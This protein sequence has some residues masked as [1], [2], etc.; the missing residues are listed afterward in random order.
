MANPIGF[1][2]LESI[3][4]FGEK[5]GKFFKFLSGNGWMNNVGIMEFENCVENG[6]EVLKGTLLILEEINIDFGK[7]GWALVLWDEEDLMGLPFSFSSKPDIELSIQFFKLGFRFQAKEDSKIFPVIW[8]A[9]EKKWVAEKVDVTENGVTRQVYAPMVFD[10]G[11]VD[12]KTGIEVGQLPDPTPD[13]PNNTSFGI[14]FD[15]EFIGNTMVNVTKAVALG[16]TGFVLEFKNLTFHFS[17]QN[18]PQGREAG[19]KGI[20]LEQCTFHFP[21]FM[22]KDDENSTA[23]IACTDLIIGTGGFS[24]HFKLTAHA[25]ANNPNEPALIKFKAGKS[26]IIV[27]DFEL[28]FDEGS[29]THGHMSGEVRFSNLKDGTEESAILAFECDITDYGFIINAEEPDGVVVD[30]GRFFEMQLFKLT[31]GIDSGE[32]VWGLKAALR[33][34]LKKGKLGKCLPSEIIYER[35]YSGQTRILP[36][37]EY[38]IVENKVKENKVKNG[39]V[40]TMESG[41]QY[42]QEFLLKLGKFAELYAFR[43][44]IGQVD[45]DPDFDAKITFD[46]KFMFGP[47][48]VS[49]KGLGVDLNFNNDPLLPR[50]NLGNTHLTASPILPSGFGIKIKTETVEGGGQLNIIDNG[51]RYEGFIS[52]NIKKKIIINGLTI[53]EFEDATGAPQFNFFVLLGVQFKPGIELGMGFTLNGVGG[54][55]AFNREIEPDKF[56]VAI[57]KPGFDNLFFPEDV[58]ENTSQIIK[59]IDEIYPFA[60]GQFV[61]GPVVKIG[62]GKPKEIVTITAALLIQVPTLRIAL[63]GVAKVMLPDTVAEKKIL[64]LQANFL[65]IYNHHD[66]EISFDASLYDSKFMV[67]TITGDICMRINWGVTKY[68]LF[69]AGGFHPGFTTLPANV[70]TTMKRLGITLSTSDDFKLA[71]SSYFAVTSNTAQFGAEAKLDV[72]LGEYRL[73]ATGSFDALF[74]FKPYQYDVRINIYGGI[75][76]GD[77]V[78]ISV[79]ANTKFTGPNPN[80]ITGYVEFNLAGVDLRF[81]IDH[82]FDTGIGQGP[83][84]T[85]DASGIEIGKLFGDA[86]SMVTFFT[87]GAHKEFA[88]IDDKYQAALAPLAPHKGIE[89]SQE[90]VPLNVKLDKVGENDVIGANEVGIQQILLNGQTLSTYAERRGFAR[91]VYQK[92][93]TEEMLTAPSFE[94]MDAGVL[95][96]LHNASTYQTPVPP[97]STAYQVVVFETDEDFNVTSTQGSSFT[98]PATISER[99]LKDNHVALLGNNISNL[100]PKNTIEYS[101]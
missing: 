98:D 11:S 80:A 36:R 51:R 88:K 68:F 49:F 60:D 57:T 19:F 100:T 81:N 45:D 12:F 70:P 95:S 32:F 75:H 86:I 82:N 101:G 52:I 7:S 77:R 30:L 44:I 9:N 53:I 23:Y 6:R 43:M 74:Y 62:W 35:L 4:K 55:F 40:Q 87:S 38:Q 56:R 78:L 79:V 10:L 8:D 26:E 50:H 90:A 93:S 92:L 63:A 34:D 64:K 67:Y 13:D 94:D 22:A 1:T 72:K 59:S 54:L 76:K 16:T 27:H 21:N 48:H 24:G 5:D 15:P 28:Q 89:I 33:A 97:V 29:V 84:T 69:S 31:F 91:G 18:P 41:V 58:T 66:K 65:A 37:W 73:N 71:L 61:F 46:G 17:N 42:H 83:R 2:S 96:S 25:H 47:V 20:A 85:L 3:I 14:E 39:T 99:L